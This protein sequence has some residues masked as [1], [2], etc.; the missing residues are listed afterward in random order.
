MDFLAGREEVAAHRVLAWHLIH[1]L[2]PEGI[3][4]DYSCEP[5][6]N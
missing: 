4:F 2:I 6:N 5:R 1:E 3:E